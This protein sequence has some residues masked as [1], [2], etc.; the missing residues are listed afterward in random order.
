MRANAAEQK[1]IVDIMNGKVAQILAIEEP[2]GIRFKENDMRARIEYFHDAVRALTSGTAD[3]Y[4]KHSRLSVEHL[5]YDI[6]QL[7]QVQQRP[8][9]AGY[10]GPSATASGNALVKMGQRGDSPS[11]SERQDLMQHYADYTVFFVALFAEV[12][13]KNYHARVD[14][15][16]TAV[17]DVGLVEQV[18]EQLEAGKLDV[19]TALHELDQVELDDLRERTK[20]ALRSGKLKGQQQTVLKQFLQQTEKKLEQERDQI[21]QAHMNYRLGQ[22]STYEN[23][24][25]TVKKLAAQGLNLAGKFVDNA[26]RNAQQGKGRGV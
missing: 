8:L 1:A 3:P 13:D 4:A 25:D 2:W 7:Q 11:R 6:S 22:L 23:S 21:E 10:R 15:V 24:K 5:A 9:G 19:Q 20:E 17:S 14:E 18:I 12:A 16:D 26:M